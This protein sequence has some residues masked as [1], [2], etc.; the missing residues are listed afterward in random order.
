MAVD[1]IRKTTDRT[2]RTD[3]AV[4]PDGSGA[5]ADQPD[6]LG[7]PLEFANRR[8]RKKLRVRRAI[9]ANLLRHDAPTGSYYSTRR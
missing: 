3:K 1:R 4:P 9:D 8:L 6:A 5:D 2:V 7:K